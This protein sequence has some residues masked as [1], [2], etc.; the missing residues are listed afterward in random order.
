MSAL[1][2]QHASRVPSQSQ[3]H[4][5][6]AKKPLPHPPLRS[7]SFSRDR[8]A[9]RRGLRA[10]DPSPPH[11]Q[12][13]QD[14]QRRPTSR[15]EQDHHQTSPL[16]NGSPANSLSLTSAHKATSRP[17]Q[18]RKHSHGLSWT[19]HTRDSLVDNL[20]LSL[21]QISHHP[22]VDTAH[23]SFDSKRAPDSSAASSPSGAGPMSQFTAYRTRGHNHS[24]SIS[25]EQDRNESP[26]RY[27]AQ[28]SP[29]A[30]RPSALSASRIMSGMR[31]SRQESVDT[32]QSSEMA[33]PTRGW[34]RHGSKSSDVTTGDYASPSPN[35]HFAR[36][37]SRERDVRNQNRD[38]SRSRP[39]RIQDSI[40]SR[41]RPVPSTGS[42][43]N[44]APEPSIPSG[45][46]SSTKDSQNATRQTQDSMPN[47]RAGAPTRKQSSQSQVDLPKS[48]KL[49]HDIPEG[50]RAQA[51]DFVRA[52][53]MKS[54]QHPAASGTAA[55]A[56]P[57]GSTQKHASGQPE[58]RRGF[59]KR[60]FGSSNS[61][62][63]LNSS[64][65]TNGSPSVSRQGS[66]SNIHFPNGHS[67]TQ[68]RDR[69][70]SPAPSSTRELNKKPS[71]FFRRRKKSVTDPTEPP[72][73]PTPQ[74]IASGPESIASPTRSS[75]YKAM[76]PYLSGSAT[77]PT[78]KPQA[79]EATI[80]ETIR[81]R[82]EETSPSI[83]DSDDPELF[84]SG[85]DKSPDAP[86]R[87]KSISANS[88]SD[89]RRPSEIP[90]IPD[91]PLRNGSV[92]TGGASPTLQMKSRKKDKPTSLSPPPVRVRAFPSTDRDN[93]SVGSQSSKGHAN[94]VSPINS[95]PASAETRKSSTTKAVNLVVDTASPRTEQEEVGLARPGRQPS[96]V[97]GS[98]EIFVT[99]HEKDTFLTPLHDN[100][101]EPKM[102]ARITS[103]DD[104]G[105]TYEQPDAVPALQLDGQA[106]SPHLGHLRGE[107]F[108]SDAIRN[109]SVATTATAMS[110]M[111]G[112]LEGPTF[113]DREH[114]LSIY[115]CDEDFMPRVTAA[116]FL[117]DR[118]TASINTLRAY[119][120]LYNFTGQTI[121]GG[122]RMLCNRLLLKAESQQVDRI[123]DAFASRWCEC[124]PEHGF[125]LKDVVHTMCYSLLLL[126]TDLHMADIESKMTRAQFVKNTL[127]TIK[128]VV[129][130]AA[131][132]DFDP[133]DRPTPIDRPGMQWHDS[134]NSIT[135]TDSG[136]SDHRRTSVDSR[137]P[138]LTKRMSWSLGMGTKE[139]EMLLIPNS[140][141][142]ALVSEKFDGKPAEWHYELESILKS[143]FTA[144]KN[145]ALP[146]NKEGRPGLRRTNSLKSMAPSEM[147]M[148][149][150]KTDFYSM[151]GRWGRNRTRSKFYGSSTLA[152]SRTSFDDGGSI[153][154]NAASKFSLGKTMTTMS[155]DNYG[156][157]L[158]PDQGFPQTIG[159]ANALSQS[160]AREDGVEDD[161]MSVNPQKF[162]LEDDS[163]ELAG[164]PWAKEGIL[165]HKHH[166]EATEKKA[167]ERNWNECFAVI[168]KGYLRLFSFNSKGGKTGS[169]GVRKSMQKGK[170]ASIAP[171]VVG[172]GNWMQNAESLGS[173]LLRQTIASTLPP[174][175][176]SKARPNVWAL[177]LPTGAVHLFQVGTAEIAREFMNT[178]NYWSARLSKEP[179]QGGVDNIE[180]GWG[181][182][183]IT[184]SLIHPSLIAATASSS[185][186]PNSPKPPS[187][188]A[189]ST[190]NS[191]SVPTGAG[192]RA[193]IAGSMRNSIDHGMMRARSAGDKAHL[194]EWKPP[195]QS[196]MASQLME[197][198][199]LKGLKDYVASVEAELQKHNELRGQIPGAYTPRHPN[200]AKAIANWEKKS[201]YLLR[202]NVKFRTYIDALNLAQEEKKKIDVDRAERE[203][204]KEER[205]QKKRDRELAAE[206][207][208]GVERE[209]AQ[210]ELEGGSG[211]GSKEGTPRVGSVGGMTTLAEVKVAVQT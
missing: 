105:L 102:E 200:L 82:K 151:S 140:G 85:Y 45:P 201:A 83:E 144:I 3:S 113:E 104:L 172:G 6:D 101:Q 77:T 58:E 50:V 148:R 81:K 132:E 108:G 49:P 28:D 182:A 34:S 185:P 74:G 48:P 209:K 66:Y 184:P 109:M 13:C 10:V 125:K 88:I 173:F 198:D 199:Q 164:A 195:A 207:L 160:N 39:G 36:E 99:P 146:L 29:H 98:E 210:M 116:Q 162:L 114:A 96:P 202:E 84:H 61:R 37:A 70:A 63:N 205:A 44:H 67:A 94:P 165:K 188:D 60:V 161:N 95:N 47:Q 20:L 136:D 23:P 2:A 71:S 197:V 118:K 192:T 32:Q 154:S 18:H 33:R 159:F 147:S 206:R 166:L 176:Y 180:Y 145:E 175:G 42:P 135:A 57:P 131:P 38:R 142:N 130:D 79:R 194:E 107:R 112:I 65:S 1:Q 25:S 30:R 41:G 183:I 24:S 191:I 187:R 158:G 19:S 72:S 157:A 31:S 27:A 103:P 196:M 106:S 204:E 169:L 177:S 137:R 86:I 121:L 193:S 100:P 179:L 178:A 17:E 52:S 152:S 128:R 189:H 51:G 110:S 139:E 15:D 149:S 43:L 122:M 16:Q 115:N 133:A 87:G 21:D 35:R 129:A 190:Q 119:I 46:A 97:D 186:D 117:G 8:K 134:S 62:T 167:K 26:N 126:N 7:L 80:Q 64:E 168:E 5:P 170:A 11:H 93:E 163:L 40:L 69:D 73:L 127:P 90:S 111:T 150:R 89:P 9:S 124:N 59:F 22:P 91:L 208:A 153:F 54:L 78:Q 181:D 174:P 4:T 68:R 53:S 12:H 203:Q 55:A 171:S 211:G 155:T 56:T 141:S 143:F 123:L 92:A 14:V 76:D 138:T 120:E 75:L 156:M